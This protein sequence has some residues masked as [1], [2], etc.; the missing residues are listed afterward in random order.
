MLTERMN[1]YESRQQ[2]KARSAVANS[3]T[4]PEAPS[5]GIVTAMAR[6]SSK[7]AFSEEP[8]AP[9]VPE[10]AMMAGSTH[11]VSTNWL[12]KAGTLTSWATL[13]EKKALNWLLEPTAWASSAASYLPWLEVADP[14]AMPRTASKYQRPDST[15]SSTT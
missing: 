8:T 2:K 4:K 1:V 3:S 13:T 11:M 7:E 10:N 15:L 9:A 5:S 6:I 14:P 12:K